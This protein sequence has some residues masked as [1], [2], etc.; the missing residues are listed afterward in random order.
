M[1]AGP[2]IRKGQSDALVYLFDLFPT[3]CELT[4][5]AVPN[6]CEGVSLAAALKGEAK[7]PR[8]TLF[9]AYRDCQRMVRD[10]R[11]KLIDY[12]KVGRVQLFD[13]SKDADE[14]EDLSAKPEHNGRVAAMQAKLKEQQKSWNDPLAKK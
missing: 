14:M 10:E 7:P 8:E 12:P 2:G 4:A 11:W 6:V 3:L 13:L 5:V 9:A 1:I